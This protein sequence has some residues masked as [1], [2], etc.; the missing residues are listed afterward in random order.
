MTYIDKAFYELTS[1]LLSLSKNKIFNNIKNNYLKVPDNIKNGIEDFFKKFNYWGKLDYKNNEFE[2]LENRTNSIYNNLDKF[3]WLYEKLV[4]YRSKKILYAILNN[5]YNYDF[6]TL[7]S[8]FENNYPYYFD[9]D[10]VKCSNDEVVVDL[11]AYTGDTIT[12]YLR[13]YNKR[14]KKI[15]A[16]EITDSSFKI[17]ENKFSENDD[18]ILKKKAVSDKSSTMYLRENSYGNE[19]ANGISNKGS[20]K[21]DVVSIDEDIKDD[22]SLIKMDIE[23]LEY[24]AMLVCS[25]HIINNKPKLLISVYHNHQ[26]IYR[27]P[28]LIETLKPGYKFYLRYHG[29]NIFPTEVTLIAIYEDKN[30]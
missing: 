15:Y 2:E 18:I 8:C 26:D 30:N 9:L 20:K 1:H 4:D 7:R 27:I 5:W 23:G 22:I 16:Y 24:K 25:N 10:L 19:D 6:I 3:I 28:L 14:Y 12:D 17:L 11:G 21:I 13:M 29:N